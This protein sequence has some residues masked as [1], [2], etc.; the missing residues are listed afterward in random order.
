MGF[1]NAGEDKTTDL[2]DGTVAVPANW[3]VGSGTGA[4]A[5]AKGDTALG[6]EVESR[7]I[8]T[9]SQPT[10]DTNRHVGEV[11]YTATRTITEAG[12]FDAASV[13]NMPM[14]EV[15]AGIGVTSGDRIEFTFDLTTA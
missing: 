3:Y 2:W 9:D 15:F 8:T 13:G 14:R 10:T 5:F 12:I 11:T 6:T 4:V 1:T 7:V